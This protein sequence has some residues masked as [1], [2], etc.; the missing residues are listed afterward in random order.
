ME[1]ERIWPRIA[2]VAISGTS[3]VES[4]GYDIPVSVGQN[5][6]LFLIYLM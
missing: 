4:S 3:G 1:D 2:P 5:Y 6:V